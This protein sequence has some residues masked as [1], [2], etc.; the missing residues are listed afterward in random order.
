MKKKILLILIP[1]M[2]IL[3]GISAGAYYI[4]DSQ[5]NIDTIYPGVKIDEFQVGNM[6]KGHAL[7]YIKESRENEILGKTMKLNYEDNIYN[8]GLKDLDY[9]YDYEQAVNEAYELGRQGKLFQR[10]KDIREIKEKGYIVPLK[11]SYSQSKLSEIAHNISQELYKESKDAE[12][13]FNGGNIII[14]EEEIGRKVD[15]NKLIQLIKDN[16]EGLDDIEIPVEIVQPKYTKEY[17]GRINGVIGEYSTDFKNSGIGRKKNIKLSAESLNGKIIHPGESIS[18]NET[19][20]PRQKQ[21]GYEEAP[22][23]VGGQLTPGIG[24]GVCQTSTTLYNALL[25]ADVTILERHPHSIPPAYINKGQDA[26]VATGYLDLRFRNDF[27]YPIYISSKVVGDRV[28]FYVYGDKANRDY[29]VSIQ[30]EI[31]ETIPYEVIENLDSNIQ[32]GNKELVE[33]G[34]NGYKVRTYKSIIKNGKVVERK[35][36]TSD[37]YREKNYLYKIG[38]EKVEVPISEEPVEDEI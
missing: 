35:Q 4:Y 10:Y 13:N 28:Y 24:G 22:V 12:F 26:A 3:A 2:I 9:T 8:I 16:I 23:I 18:Y 1:L 33:Q 15:D 11:S 14:K 36:I 32:P 19:T 25:L 30:P 37:Y 27:D 20:G 21:F 34:R 7:N 6:T 38:P 29:A 31:I 5:I 17:Y